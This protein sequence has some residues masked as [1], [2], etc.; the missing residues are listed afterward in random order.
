MLSGSAK[1]LRA[2]QG[3][4]GLPGDPWPCAASGLL[5][6]MYSLT[7]NMNCPPESPVLRADG[8]WGSDEISR[9]QV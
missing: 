5:D 7:L 2:L 9:A 1:W 6:G 8:L 4:A 3:I